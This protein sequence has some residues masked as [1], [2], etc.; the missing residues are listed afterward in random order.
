MARLSRAFVCALAAVVG[1]PGGSGAGRSVPEAGGRS[2]ARLSIV[3]TAPHDGAATIGASARLL[4]YRGIDVE[5]AQVLAGT[6]SAAR[7][8]SS[9]GGGCGLV[10]DEALLN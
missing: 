7:D 6:P 8:S 3:V 9:G 10:D 2:F 1:R 4:R 5:S